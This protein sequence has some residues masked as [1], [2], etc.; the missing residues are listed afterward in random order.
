[1]TIDKFDLCKFDKIKL[2]N[3]VQVYMDVMFF[4]ETSKI[5]IYVIKRKFI[6]TAYKI[7][8]KKKT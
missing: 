5:N 6:A 2:L 4:S 3:P 7:K 1:M 8:L